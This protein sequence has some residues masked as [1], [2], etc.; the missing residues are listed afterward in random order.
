MGNVIVSV[1]TPTFNRKEKLANLYHSLVIQSDKRFEWIIIDDGSIDQTEVYVGEIIK[2]QKI[3]ITYKKKKNQ[4]KHSALNYSHNYINGKYVVIVDSDDVLLPNAINDI[5]VLWEK[6]GNDSQVAGITFQKISSNGIISD[7]KIKGEYI[8][9]MCKEF[10][11][12]FRGEHCEVFR[13]EIFTSKEFPIFLNENFMAEGVMWYLITQGKK[14]VYTELPIYRFEY[15]QDGLTRN[16]RKIMADNPNGAYWNAIQMI[17]SEFGIKVKIKNG[18]LAIYYG[19]L[20]K[21]DFKVIRKEINN[22]WIYFVAIVPYLWVKI[23]WNKY[24]N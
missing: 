14:T 1:V 24:V 3:N 10:H 15:L 16:I 2:E 13:K 8:S 20:S 11:G 6:Y 4:G 22:K 21:K 23:L 17:N 5:V 18:I 12:G 7:T 19:W 9:S